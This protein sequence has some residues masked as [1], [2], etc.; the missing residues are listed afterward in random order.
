MTPFPRILPQP[1]REEEGGR[2][3]P[4]P[5]PLV[6]KGSKPAPSQASSCLLFPPGRAVNRRKPQRAGAGPGVIFTAALSPSRGLSSPMGAAP[7]PP[8]SPAPAWG[9]QRWHRTGWGGGAGKDT[10]H[11]KFSSQPLG[12]RLEKPPVLPWDPSAPS[13]PPHGLWMESWVQPSPGS[14]QGLRGPGGSSGDK[15]MAFGPGPA[16][17]GAPSLDERGAGSER[18]WPPPTPVPSCSAAAGELVPGRYPAP[19]CT[20]APVPGRGWSQYPWAEE[21]RN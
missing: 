9:L 10:L 13:I 15:A 12:A 16:G 5:S 18:C 14:L 11:P 7:D 17:Q 8:P 2:V 21:N 3:L 19:P 6:A 20:T 1:A 4:A